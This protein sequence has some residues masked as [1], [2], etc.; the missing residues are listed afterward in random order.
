M[1]LDMQTRIK[2]LGFTMPDIASTGEEAIR[3]VEEIRPDL[4]LMDI[5]LPG[6]IDG[7]SVAER[8]KPRF[9]IPII[10][11]TA[12]A[13][14][15]TLQR[16]KIT[17]PYGYIVKPFRERELAVTIDVALYKHKM[18]NKLKESER[19]LS[20]TLRSI[21]DGVIAI[22]RESSITFMNRVAEELT[23]WKL[24]EVLN[25][26]LTACFKLIN[27]E[28]RRPVENPAAR[29]LL[30]GTIKGLANHTLLITRDGTEIPIDD[31]AA[32]I[33]DDRGNVTG[34]VL[35]F[36]D[37]KE[38]EKAETELHQ[39][40][41][42]LK[43]KTLQLEASNKELE[44]FSYSVSHD[45][46]A[47]LRGIDGF[48]GMLMKDLGNDLNSEQKR[49]FDVIRR[50]TVQMGQLIDDLLAFS[51]IGRTSLMRI[52]IEM[53]NLI[54]RVIEQLRS[55]EPERK[56][57]IRKKD[58]PACAGDPD[59]IKQVWAN[60]ISNAL[61][62]T[63]HRRETLIEIGGKSEV[64]WITYWVKDNGIGFDMRYY[65]KLFE[66]FQRLHSDADFEGTGVGLANVKKIIIRHYGKVWA[67]GKV[68]KGA[69]FYFSLPTITNRKRIEHER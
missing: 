51:R 33:K 64:D 50:N 18:E 44:S 4:V 62:F 12:Y 10:Y 68:G 40:Y 42:K 49:K 13:D 19:W 25:K 60:L 32:P 35:V 41:E 3:M 39:T 30:D 9:D 28:T 46:R 43:E 54:D 6:E 27:R 7:V 48:S 58:M 45:L 11:V 66:V 36:R 69:T 38:R 14:E 34:A 15:A 47:P 52:P 59:L 1:A 56:V 37:I 24:E 26:K 5:M 29:V 31:T 67:E 20:T 63:R 2:S 23:G 65:D 55:I 53:G 21:G 8:I 22:D 16:A 17:E 57:E 61:K